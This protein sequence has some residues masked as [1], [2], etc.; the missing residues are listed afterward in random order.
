MDVEFLR[1]T[2]YPF[3]RGAMRVY[4]EMLEREGNALV[5]PVSVSPEYRGAE[6]N[7]WGRNASF[8]L[9]CIHMLCEALLDS[10]AV[11]GETPRPVWREIREK[12]PKACLCD[13]T[14][15]ETAATRYRP[16]MIALWEG[17]EL[18]ESHRHHSHLA[19]ICP[20]DVFDLDDPEWRSILEH[21]LA[22]WIYRGMGLWSGWC[23]PWAAMIHTRFGNADMAATLLE[24]W[25]RVF[26]NEGGGT[27]HDCHFPGFTLIGAGATHA[28]DKRNEIMQMD[29][30]M[31]CTAALLDMMLH[32]RRGVQVLFAGAPSRWK[33]VAFQG[34]RTEG[35]YV[36]GAAREQGVVKQVVVKSMAGG[37]FRLLN[38]WAGKAA[39]RR[40]RKTTTV[41]GK[42]LD[43][44]M[45]PGE[46]VK[47]T[48][49]CR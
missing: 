21:S 45:Q 19:G 1:R 10:A 4:E 12:L 7:A 20:F 6:M 22:H 49:A 16:R 27:L 48:A 23:V 8:Q 34:I 46:A 31:S 43:I 24:I 15:P 37:V 28:R 44:P 9:A 11:L 17:V 5:L 35:A 25:E 33:R 32:T 14:P 30:G 39:V 2:A 26:T 41:T 40:G 38:P 36:V 42:V 3:M 47:I 18:V 29:A 13:E